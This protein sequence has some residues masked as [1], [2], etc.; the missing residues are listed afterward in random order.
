ME[1]YTAV[2]EQHMATK[3][4]QQE[5]CY[6]WTKIETL[7]Y[8]SL[9]HLDPK[10]QNIK[11]IKI[12]PRLHIIFVLVSDVDNVLYRL[13]DTEFIQ[14]DNG[15]ILSNHRFYIP[16]IW[17]RWNLKQSPFLHPSDLFICCL[18]IGTCASFVVQAPFT[19][20]PTTLVLRSVAFAIYQITVVCV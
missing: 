1:W 11:I 7:I 3:I 17:S 2:Y 8:E 5:L 20:F 19:S 16:V 6:D 18:I 13:S 12:V 15:G 10:C 14:K 4:L 9:E